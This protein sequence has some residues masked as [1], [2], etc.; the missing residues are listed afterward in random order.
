MVL[1]KKLPHLVLDDDF[2]HPKVLLVCALPVE[3]TRLGKNGGER[4]ILSVVIPTLGTGDLPIALVKDLLEQ[5]NVHDFE[6]IVVFNP[7]AALTES[8]RT[9]LEELDPRIRC[10]TS[11]FL[12]V[13][14]ARNV[15]LRA[16]QGKVVLFLD[17]DCRILDDHFLHKHVLLH[18]TNPLTTAI[19][20]AYEISSY[21]GWISKSYQFAQMNWIESGLYSPSQLKKAGLSPAAFLLG[22]NC[23][24]KRDNLLGEEFDENLV[25]GG[26]ET[27][28]FLRLSQTG[29][30]FSL[31]DKIAVFHRC[32]LGAWRF[33]RKSFLQGIGS[34]YIR[35]RGLKHSFM[36]GH[37]PKRPSAPIAFALFF[38]D[39]VFRA[40]EIYHERTGSL[41]IETSAA[42]RSLAAAVGEKA[43]SYWEIFYGFIRTSW[44]AAKLLRLKSQKSESLSD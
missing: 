39:V 16:C 15:G 10:F 33:L 32:E 20:G 11:P 23:S 9:G 4:M 43:Q 24:F 30:R 19:G 8:K 38:Y 3:K 36:N 34:S 25:F 26:T 14:R 42:R 29:H 6:I 27:E 37:A 21:S 31:S 35:S 41:Q 44:T 28:L 5:V 40:G 17:D 12:G 13:N 7:A 2:S 22:G 18:E 1:S